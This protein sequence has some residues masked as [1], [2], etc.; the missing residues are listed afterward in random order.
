MAQQEIF[1]PESQQLAHR[2]AT[3]F[4]AKKE[5]SQ[6]H[7]WQNLMRPKLYTYLGWLNDTYFP[8]DSPEQFTPMDGVRVLDLMGRNHLMANVLTTPEYEDIID[9]EKVLRGHEDVT[10]GVARCIDGR[11]PNQDNRLIKIQE[12][13]A[14]LLDTKKVTNP[15]TK[16]EKTILTSGRMVEAIKAEASKGPLLQILVAHTDQVGKPCDCGAMNALKGQ[17]PEGTDLLLENIK[18][19]KNAASAIDNLYNEE[20]AYNIKKGKMNQNFQQRTAITAV[21]E[22]STQGIVLGYKEDGVEMYSTTS[23]ARE[24]ASM[25]N[26]YVGALTGKTT[27]ITEVVSNEKRIFEVTQSLLDTSSLFFNRTMEY[28]QN[29]PTLSDLNEAQRHALVFYLGRTTAIQLLT[30]SFDPDVPNPFR[31]HDEEFQSISANDAMVGQILPGQVFCSSPH[32][33]KAVDHIATQYNLMNHYVPERKKPDILF[34]S[35]S[36]SRAVPENLRDASKG[37]TLEMLQN[38]FTNPELQALIQAHELLPVPVIIDD[39]TRDITHI[40]EPVGA[41]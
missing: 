33:S 4:P 6:F 8:K 26:D 18:L 14:G 20:I 27:D 7:E 15:V 37:L 34:I 17:Y 21:Y 3:L 5:F 11:L 16:T 2:L 9:Q 36:H 29:S 38:I 40:F 23:I 39:K 10:I 28:I 32:T 19:H 31:V 13:K 35:Q 41:L 24:M 25:K 12:S 1:R 22:T 30:A